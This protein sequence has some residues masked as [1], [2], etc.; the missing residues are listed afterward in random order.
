MTYISV[1]NNQPGYD[2][3]KGGDFGLIVF[4]NLKIMGTFYL[5]CDHFGDTT[6]PILALNLVLNDYVVESANDC[7]PF[8]QHWTI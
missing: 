6:Q 8:T 1:P 3:L 2:E 7:C 4:Y 5:T